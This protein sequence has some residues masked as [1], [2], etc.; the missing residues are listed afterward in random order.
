LEA[1][2]GEV[3]SRLQEWRG[4]RILNSLESRRKEGREK[5]EEGKE[6]D[7]YVM[8]RGRSVESSRG[9]A[10]IHASRSR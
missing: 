9:N 10:S 1:K 5:R 7:R 2:D 4:I 6:R 8:Y 3:M